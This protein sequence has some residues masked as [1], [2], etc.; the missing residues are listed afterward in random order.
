MELSSDFWKALALACIVCRWLELSRQRGLSGKRPLLHE[1]LFRIHL[2]TNCGERWCVV[3]FPPPPPPFPCCCRGKKDLAETIGCELSEFMFTLNGSRCN[4]W[5]TYKLTCLLWPSQPRL[6][7]SPS[8]FLNYI[9]FWSH[10]CFLRQQTSN[11]E[12]SPVS[13]K[14]EISV[15]WSWVRSSCC[16]DVTASPDCHEWILMAEEIRWTCPVSYLD[17]EK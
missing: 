11:N 17:F 13:W 8:S 16:V 5:K 9:K 3:P 6:S 4:M 14:G 15:P 10:V 7:C 12:V 2:A 1:I